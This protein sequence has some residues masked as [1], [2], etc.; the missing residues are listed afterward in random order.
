MVFGSQLLLGNV[1]QS[2]DGLAERGHVR[3]AF[4]SSVSVLRSTCGLVRLVPGYETAVLSFRLALR[5]AELLDTGQRTE[6]TTL[7]R[8]GVAA[9]S[10]EDA[11]TA[12]LL[13]LCRCLQRT[14]RPRTQRRSSWRTCGTSRD[15]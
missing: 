10:W 13:S 5:L 1:L 4:K 6:V 3:E 12:V 14:R 8:P 2:A 7:S 11:F 9:F 15:K